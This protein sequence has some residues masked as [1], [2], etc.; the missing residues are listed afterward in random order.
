[1]SIALLLELTI[2][3]WLNS[4]MDFLWSQ[5]EGLLKQSCLTDEDSANCRDFQEEESNY[6]KENQNFSKPQLLNIF[7]YPFFFISTS[8]YRCCLLPQST[9]GYLHKSE[10][11][12]L[13]YS[14]WKYYYNH[15]GGWR[16]R[17]VSQIKHDTSKEI[18]NFRS[19]TVKYFWLFI[20]FCISTSGYRCCKTIG[21]MCMELSACIWGCLTGLLQLEILLQLENEGEGRAHRL[22]NLPQK[23]SK[24][25]E[26][27]LLNICRRSI[28]F[29]YWQ[30]VTIDRRV[31]AQSMWTYLCFVTG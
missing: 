17:Q 10:A 24:F 22:S 30:D 23:K 11:S 31:L 21:T 29:V 15:I 6:L 19:T 16:W 8:C 18:K 26:T 25:S 13:T 1:M 2:C 28:F 27:L 12:I 3:E 9:W 14:N 20:F 4:T 5:L 7:G